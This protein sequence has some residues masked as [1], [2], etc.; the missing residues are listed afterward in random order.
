[1]NHI[2]LMMSLFGE[3]KELSVGERLIEVGRNAHPDNQEVQLGLDRVERDLEAKK[4]K[5]YD[6]MF[7]IPRSN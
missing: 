5:I 2:H 3:L 1:M 4:S 6:Q 7:W